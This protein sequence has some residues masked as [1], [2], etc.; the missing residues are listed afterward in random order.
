M[1]AD[2]PEV[3]D[4]FQFDGKFL[5]ANPYGFGHINDTYS[6]WFRKNGAGYRYLLQRIN[7]NVF[8]QPAELMQ[9]IERVTRHLRHKIV[10]AGGNPDRETLTLIPTHAGESYYV[11][12][13]GNY[14]R[15]YIF[16]EDAL[17]HQVVKHPA[18]IYHAAKAFGK[19]QQLLTR[20]SFD[21]THIKNSRY[22]QSR[23]GADQTLP[24]PARAMAGKNIEPALLSGQ[25][26]LNG[27]PPPIMAT[28]F[29]PAIGL[30][31]NRP[32]SKP[33]G[34]TTIGPG[35]CVAKTEPCHQDHT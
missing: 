32:Q 16:I 34:S 24:S 2:I 9:N 10:T 22:R 23:L 8:K 3:V 15:A 12:S 11:T 1:K 35:R 19:F 20:L 27:K 5:E 30:E 25:R 28:R 13:T 26:W 17:A 21:I 33:P 6:V 7:H 18:H 29:G 14:W 31:P 4:N